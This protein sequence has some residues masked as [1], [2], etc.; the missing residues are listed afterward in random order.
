MAP[1]FILRSIT[2]DALEYQQTLD[3]EN[4]WPEKLM[5]AITLPHKA[6]AA[7]DTLTAIVKLSPLAKGIYVQA[8]TSSINETTKICTRGLTHENL[9]V[10]ASVTHEIID[11]QAVEVEVA[12]PN[13]ALTA[14]S[15]HTPQSASPH[16]GPSSLYHHLHHSS[17]QQE[18]QE[19]FGLDNNDVVT[20]IN[21]S[22]PPSSAYPLLYS[23]SGAV[24]PIITPPRS[25]SPTHQHAPLPL[26]VNPMTS[27][28]TSPSFFS[29]TI[30]PSH[31]LEPI[32]ISH[33]I[34][35]NIFIRNQD[36]HVS[37]L[38]CS[39]PIQ[40][41][42]GVFLNESR[43]FTMRSRRLLLRASGLG[44]VLN[45]GGEEGSDDADDDGAEVDEEGRIMETDR[46]LPSYPAHVRD[47]VANM[48]LSEAVTMRVSNP[49]V[50]R[51]GPIAGTAS[52]SGSSGLNTSESIGRGESEIIRPLI[53]SV[54]A[55][56]SVSAN[57]S[58]SHTQPHSRASRSG[59]ST[60]A[61]QPLQQ[62]QVHMMSHLPHVPE[63]GSSPL[64]WV[65]SE[66]LLSLSLDEEAV[67]RIGGVSSSV[68]GQQERQS[69]QHQQRSSRTVRWDSRAASPEP[70]APPSITTTDSHDNGTSSIPEGSSSSGFVS[71]FQSLFKAIKPLTA[72][73]GHHTHSHRPMQPRS[74]P[75][76][77]LMGLQSTPTGTVGD[78][79][80]RA[81]VIDSNSNQIYVTPGLSLTHL[82]SD[83]SPVSSLT[84]SPAP[85]NETNGFTSTSTSPSFQS[86]RANHTCA[87]TSSP[88]SLSSD[89]NGLECTS[90]NTS[91]TP[92]FLQSHQ[93]EC[94]DPSLRVYRAF[95]AVPDYSI[96]SR[97]FIGGVP[98][99]SSMRGLPSYEEAEAQ[100]RA[101][102][103]LRDQ[104]METQNQ[105]KTRLPIPN[106]GQTS[107][108]AQTPMQSQHQLMNDKERMKMKMKERG[109]MSEPDL[110][111]RAAGVRFG[112]GTQ[113]RIESEGRSMYS[114]GVGVVQQLQDDNGEDDDEDDDDAGST[115]AIQMQTKRARP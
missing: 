70:S 10:V 89:P 96:A 9:R 81:S 34:R 104:E 37:E 49:W 72:L 99:L 21:L 50:G 58:A 59:R 67:R 28:S 45:R 115:G 114:G 41:L 80:A 16:S 63:L 51:V 19:D 35:W 91:H 101:A 71:P 38:R 17:H 94:Q 2:R 27:Q 31:S 100:R 95:T 30:T 109:S 48:Y 112:S 24:S 53:A 29:S 4:T 92:P 106:Q 36:G 102:Q 1:V 110:A 61:I 111:G 74:R 42:D 57:R 43:G 56:D 113:V 14:H 60:P 46:E 6:W 73:A 66:L 90:A 79:S 40:I 20:H 85:Q 84:P 15:T 23:A 11:H 44:S 107:I 88:A 39:L 26:S 77:P 22:I 62:Q 52:G 103:A 8:I 18:E 54:N 75:T 87:V 47:R 55:N 64:D 65:N 86:L 83:S 13:Q 69:Q 76:A 93:T 98:P 33:R 3:I 108:Q 7:G 32:L 5:Y 68:G 97:G 78:R 82:S 25:M 105:M 12:S